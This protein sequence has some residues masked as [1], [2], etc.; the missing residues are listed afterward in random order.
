[1]TAQPHIVKLWSWGGQTQCHDY[2]FSDGSI[3]CLHA[4]EA[5]ELRIERRQQLCDHEWQHESIIQPGGRGYS[6]SWCSKC[7][8]SAFAYEQGQSL[9][10]PHHQEGGK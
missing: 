4:S 9:S 7:K 10:R 2:L 1:M 5:R 3:R 8:I 6:S